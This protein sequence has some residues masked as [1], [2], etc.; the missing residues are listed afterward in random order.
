MDEERGV[1]RPIVGM[2]K[3]G[4]CRGGDARQ[5]GHKIYSREK[6]QTKYPLRNIVKIV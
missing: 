6:L 1:R 5:Y 2:L 4:E 3:Q